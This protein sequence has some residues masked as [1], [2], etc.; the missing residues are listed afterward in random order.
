MSDV[1]ILT[2]ALNRAW[3]VD[4]TGRVLHELDGVTTAN[5]GTR[6]A[7]TTGRRLCPRGRW[8]PAERGCLAR[9]VAPKES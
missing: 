6:L 9:A 8:S 7:S 1:L 5:A 2:E 4:E 3:L